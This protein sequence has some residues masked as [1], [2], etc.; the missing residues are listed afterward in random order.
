MY[1]ELREKISKLYHNL[2]KDFN[3]FLSNGD[4]IYGIQ[5]IPIDEYLLVVTD[6]RYFNGIGFY[7]NVFYP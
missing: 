7:K 2:S 6:K 4:K 1:I 5:D 3:I